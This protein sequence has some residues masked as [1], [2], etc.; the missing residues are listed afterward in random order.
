MKLVPVSVTRVVPF[1]GPFHGDSLVMDT[2]TNSNRAVHRSNMDMVERWLL[3]SGIGDDVV[4]CDR[5]R[6]HMR[7]TFTL[8][9]G[10]DEERKDHKETTYEP[11]ECAYNSELQYARLER[12]VQRS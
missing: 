5:I 9:Q 6:D 3:L 11:C 10:L 8:T 1:S 12:F 2:D 7:Y 4:L